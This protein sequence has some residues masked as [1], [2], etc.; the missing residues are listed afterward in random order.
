MLTTF[1]NVHNALGLCTKFTLIAVLVLEWCERKILL[2]AGGWRLVLELCERK[3]LL[4]DWRK[5][6][7]NRVIFT[8]PQPDI[9]RYM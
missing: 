9:S 4:A 7:A 5:Q 1:A 8:I 3:I 6:T 2:A